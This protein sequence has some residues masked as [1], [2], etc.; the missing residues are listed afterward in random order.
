MR[1]TLNVYWGTRLT[2]SLREDD[3]GRFEFQYA[4]DWLA[5]ADTMPISVRLPLR[6]EPFDDDNCR[7][8]FGNLLPEGTT[9]RL[10]TGKLG[11]SESNDFKLLEILGG[12]CA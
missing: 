4:S 7:V 2:G 12:E 10:I 8:F 3:A 9:R 6:P 5:A 11:I 1:G